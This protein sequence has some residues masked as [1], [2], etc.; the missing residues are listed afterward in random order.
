M[1]KNKLSLNKILFAMFLLALSASIVFGVGI[2]KRKPVGKTYSY[3][4]DDGITMGIVFVKGLDLN[5][6][7]TVGGNEYNV[8]DSG[9]NLLTNTLATAPIA[10]VSVLK[11][12]SFF[13]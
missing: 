5:V 12:S 7:Q 2:F 13:V 6:Y 1:G 11:N 8:T 10:W 3:L 9:I 4:T